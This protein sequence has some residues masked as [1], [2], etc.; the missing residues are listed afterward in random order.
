MKFRSYS[1]SF[2]S[3]AVSLWN[4]F[5]TNF[6]NLP[7]LLSLKAHL[8]SL[9][10]PP[11]KSIYGIHDPVSL[12]NLFQLRVGLSKLRHHKKRHGFLDTPS[13]QC[14][15]KTGVEDCDHFFLV[16]P[17]YNSHRIVL[18]TKVNAILLNNDINHVLTT[19]IYLYGHGSLPDGDN[20]DVLLATIEFIVKS[21]RF[22][23]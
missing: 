8:V 4:N 17:F 23:N 3:N 10:R 13:D 12:R 18:R 7:T 22:S 11:P 5:I 15:C 9:F 1:G 16:C 14:L 2:F 6:Q 20:R 21:N 19:E